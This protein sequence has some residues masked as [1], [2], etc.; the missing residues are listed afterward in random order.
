MLRRLVVAVVVAVIVP[1][2]WAQEVDTS[3]KRL[4]GQAPPK[5]DS[6][7]KEEPIEH[8]R[9]ALAEGQK[10]DRSDYTVNRYL[11]FYA[12]MFSLNDGQRIEL[13]KKLEVLAEEQNAFLEGFEGEFETIR[14][15][16]AKAQA[17]AKSSEIPAE[18]QEELRVTLENMRAQMPLNDDRVEAELGK[19]LPAT[20]MEEGRQRL[21][22]HRRQQQERQ[23]HKQVRQDIDERGPMYT[24]HGQERARP[25]V[26]QTASATPAPTAPAAP[27]PA[28]VYDKPAPAEAQPVE[29][30]VLS[31]WERYGEQFIAHYR[32]DPAQQETVRRIVKELID[33]RAD[34]EA[35]HAADYEALE[36]MTEPQRRAEE[37][38]ALDKPINDMFEE[39]KQRLSEIPT[40][41]QLESF[42]DFS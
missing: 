26:G 4:R 39:L 23:A 20:Q 25:Q 41:A 36:Q 29:E 33:R 5:M 28:P 1:I 18:L 9:N 35:K 19:M 14:E 38:A 27:P 3:A 17:E 2:A 8:K 31:P 42:G 13:K 24:V 32:M 7:R 37:Q 6:S 15:K 22:E 40:T 21:A 10:R 34:Y 12:R 16:I 11:N 30:K